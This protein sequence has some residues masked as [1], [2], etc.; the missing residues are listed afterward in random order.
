MALKEQDVVLV[1]KQPDGTKTINMPVT[2][3]E[4]VEGAIKAVNS[5]KPDASGNVAI[6]SVASATKATQDGNGKVIATTYAT[7]T[8]L[9][10]K[11]D[12][13]TAFKQ[14]DADKLYLA[15]AGKAES[16]KAADTATKATQDASGNVITTFYATKTELSK[17]LDTSAAFTQATADSLYLG[18]TAKANSAA[19]ADAA[20]KATQDASGNVI[21]TTYATKTELSGKLAT[22]TY[23]ADKATFA[24]KTELT[25]LATKTEVTQGLAG[26]QPAGNYATAESVNTKI[27]LSGSRGKL[28]G[29]EAATAG[30]TVNQDS[31]DSQYASAAVTVQAGTAGT[32]WTKVVKMS[33][34]TASFTGSWFWVGGKAPEFKY[35]G[36]LVCHWNNDQ[37]LI[38][39]IS[40]AA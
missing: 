18:K 36:L 40:G 11:Q 1:T 32:S 35:P 4:N 6:T 20:T 33:A 37:G 10:T 28:A 5:V 7:K 19:S 25:P 27:N 26:K 34:G 16:A 23:N 13:A 30:T 31:P 21:T 14:V 8:E 39:Y 22:T 15:K 3:V 9:G 29:Y 24:L 2:R 12:T 38:N 17:K